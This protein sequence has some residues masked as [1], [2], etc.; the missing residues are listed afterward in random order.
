MIVC[1]S[2]GWERVKIRRFKDPPRA[3]C[4]GS[5][6]QS[7]SDLFY[8]AHQGSVSACAGAVAQGALGEGE[9]IGELTPISSNI[10][11]SHK[12]QVNEWIVIISPEHP[13]TIRFLFVHL[14]LLLGWSKLKTRRSRHLCPSSIYISSICKL[15]HF[16]GIQFWLTHTWQYIPVSNRVRTYVFKH[17]IIYI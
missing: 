13:R 7:R 12:F 4:P 14:W 9:P 8:G 1:R 5:R 2:F 6:A 15:S 10:N 17:N 11:I 3:W 16:W